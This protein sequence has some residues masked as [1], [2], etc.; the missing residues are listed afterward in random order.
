M[1]YWH[2]LRNFNC[3]IDDIA[4][5]VLESWANT[6]FRDEYMPEDAPGKQLQDAY[7]QQGLKPQ[8]DWLDLPK[9]FDWML[10]QPEGKLDIAIAAVFG[11]RYATRV[12]ES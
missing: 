4:R 6:T 3:I 12:I 7:E 8:L 10:P 11:R 2:V 1:A 9:P 5:W